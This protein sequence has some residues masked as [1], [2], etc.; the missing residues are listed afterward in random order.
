[1]ATWSK[2]KQQLQSFMSPDLEGRVEY[3]ASSYKYIKDKAGS[4]YLSVDKNEV[5]AMN[6]T[7]YNIRWYETEQE[8][9]KD[10]ESVAHVSP[11]EIQAFKEKEG[12]NIPDER[13]PVI[14]KK[15]KAQAIAKSIFVEQTILS[16][17]NFFE[18]ANTFLTSSIDSSLASDHI[19][20]N[21]FAI[22]DRRVGKSRLRKM[23]QQIN[24]KHPVVQ[25]FYH[26]RLD[27]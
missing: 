27:K 23:E 11:D 7:K 3:R 9:Y 15:R 16:K 22:I 19:L 2:V 21:V 17:S 8:I 26:L 10:Y 5:F 1:M 18:E 20:L 25:Y 13:I 14:L 24:E 4:C 6:T 12:K